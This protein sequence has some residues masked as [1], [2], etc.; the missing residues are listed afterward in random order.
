MKTCKCGHR[1]YRHKGAMDYPGGPCIE[2][3][4]RR[5]VWN[6]MPGSLIIK[7]VA[8]VLLLLALPLLTHGQERTNILVS[9]AHEAKGTEPSK[10]TKAQGPIIQ[11][12]S[13]Y[14]AHFWASSAVFLGGT[15]ADWASS[16][17]RKEAGLLKSSTD[18]LNS[19]AYWSLNLGLYGLSI[20]VQRNHPKGASIIRYIVGGVHFGGAVHNWNG[21]RRKR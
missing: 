16:R 10:S 9:S 18:G 20:I 6:E 1:R 8:R 13:R 21:A 7:S 4:C 19:A 15:T 2:C 5:F 14:D 11:P 3:D 17:G 12:T